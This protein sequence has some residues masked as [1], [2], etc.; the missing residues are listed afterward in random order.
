MQTILRLWVSL[1][2]IVLSTGT[3]LAQ[4]DLGTI[5]GT[6]SDPT[7]A[8]VPSANITITENATGLSYKVQTGA[9]GDY[10]R[11]ALKPG[12]YTVTAEAVGFRRVAQ[13]NVVV[14][15]GERVGVPITLTVGDVSES[16]VVSAEAALLQ[17][18]STTLGAHLSSTSVSELPLGGQRV[19]TYLARLSPGVLPPEAGARDAGTGGFSANGVR[20]NGQNNFLLNGVDNNV[21]VI[22]FMNGSSYV[23][24]PPPEAIGEMTVLTSGYNAEYGRA[25]GGVVNV[26]LKTGTNELHGGLWEILQNERLNANSW[27]NKRVAK[28]R[29][30]YK[31]NQFGAAA[32]GPIIKNRFFIFGDYQGTRIANMARSGLLSIPTQKMTTGDFS[33]LLGASVGSDAQGGTIVS[34]QIYDPLSTRTV[35]G[36]LVRDAFPGNIIP[37]TRIDSAAAKIMKAFPAENQP[38]KGFPLNDYYYTGVGHQDYDSGDLRSDFKLSDKDSFY[39]SLSWSD[40]SLLSGPPLPGALDGSGFGG[41][42]Q[43]DLTR[44]AQLGYTRVWSPSI[45][46][47][48]RVAFS[49]LVSSRAQALPTVD[50]YATFGIGGYNPTSVIPLNGGLPYFGFDRYSYFGAAEWLPTKEYSNVWD[51]IQNVAI[52]KGSHSFKFGGEFRP[53]QFPFLQYPDAKGRMNFTQNGTAYPSNAKGSTGAALNSVTGD[54]MASFLLGFVD[55]GKMSTANFISSQKKSYSFYAQDDWK[56]TKKLTLNLGLRYD[57][58]SPTYEKFGRQSNFS[59]QDVTLYI[60]EGNNQDAALPPNFTKAF[61]NVKVSRG[62]ISKY[63]YPWDKWD[64]GPRLGLAYNV[65]PK[66]VIR[67]GFGMFYGGEENEGGSPNLGESAPFNYTINLGRFDKTLTSIGLFDANPFFTGGL[68]GGYPKDVLTLPAPVSFIGFA[69][70]FRNPLVQ[71][72]SVAIQR[73]MP[74]QM[75]L[76]AAYTGNHQLHQNVQHTANAC[77][78]MGTTSSSITCESLRPIPNISSGTITDTFGYGN[79]SALTLKLEKRLASGLQFI[80][81]YTWGHATANSGTPLSTSYSVYDPTNYASGYANAQW[82][83]R[84]NFTTAFTYALPFGKGKSV[85]TSWNPVL[86]QVLGGW[87]TNGILTIRTGSP[88]TLSY[89]GCQGVWNSC[90]VD[91]VAGQDPNAAP[92]AGRSPNLWFNTSGVTTPAALTGGNIGAF[93]IRGPGGSTLDLSLFKTFRFTEHKDLEFRAEAFNLPNKTQLGNP[94][95]AK[96]NATFGVITTSSNERKMQF[97]LRFHF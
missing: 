19:F 6:V 46:S 38:V 76:E 25:A 53:I 86:N 36:Q 54:A 11:P 69:T 96:Q 16:V 47:E 37:T 62:Q 33:G 97:A 29:L 10:T 71:K 66:T 83:I 67:A 74:W 84:Q 91:V 35:N 20:S 93:N 44:N 65:T 28:P 9:N 79:Y 77:P 43:E 30:P 61:P 63:M 87:M 50:Q 14:T 68:A 58:F 8:I 32:G 7:G 81:S 56:V 13:Q 45:I 89:N 95:T 55:N 24:A 49:R 26:N 12:V 92:A 34:G 18:E 39:G 60:P 72:W 42:S 15:A 1:L 52:M 82:D 23:I 59:W 2:V 21:N 5:T 40:H 3:A 48:S 70:D 78:N 27:S 80:S 94:D 22:D 31:Q 17:T 88:L 73:E 64:F 41:N 51:F 4:R 90:R 85:G 57:L 75:S